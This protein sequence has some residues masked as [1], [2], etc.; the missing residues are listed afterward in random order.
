MSAPAPP[1]V[2]RISCSGRVFSSNYKASISFAVSVS[3]QSAEPLCRY[4]MAHFISLSFFLLTLDEN[5]QIF[6]HI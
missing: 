2:N 3:Y 4:E 1:L 5:S 6:Y